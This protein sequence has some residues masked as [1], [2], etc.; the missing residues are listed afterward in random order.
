MKQEDVKSITVDIKKLIYDKKTLFEKAKI[1]VKEGQIT[2]IMG[3]SGEGKSTVIKLMALLPELFDK[4]EK[5][6][7]TGTS[8][9]WGSKCMWKD[10]HYYGNKKDIVA[11]RAN[12]F[13]F[14]FQDKR[15][16]PDLTGSEN[17]MLPLILTGK[18]QPKTLFEVDE[19]WQSYLSALGLLENDLLEKKVKFMSGGEQQRIAIARALITD[20]KV[21]FADEPTTGLDPELKKKVDSIFVDEAKRNKMIVIITHDDR[22]VYLDKKQ[23][24]RIIYYLEHNNNL[25]LQQK[26]VRGSYDES[27]I[28]N[29]QC[30]RCGNEWTADDGWLQ[31]SILNTTIVID[32]C[33]KCSGVWL[34]HNEWEEIS[35]FPQSFMAELNKIK[36]KL[37]SYN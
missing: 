34:D 13:G 32:V 1:E 20:P 29:C 23:P 37:P 30:P 14:I 22:T 16:I 11:Y 27:S 12:K 6:C 8:I 33:Q 3:P 9:H 19:P 28:P 18:K 4:K 31:K 15:L 24:A 25:E 36:K 26:S 35:A 17:I 10:G 2:Y 7:F 5:I 21:I